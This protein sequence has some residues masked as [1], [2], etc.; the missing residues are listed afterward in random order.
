M[1]PEL[2]GQDPKLDFRLGTKRWAAR[3]HAIGAVGTDLHGL[4][5]L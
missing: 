4:C 2:S 3:I 1:I 5:F